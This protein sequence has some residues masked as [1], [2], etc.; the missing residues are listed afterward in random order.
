VGGIII[1]LGRVPVG[2]K[3]STW[4]IMY[5]LVLIGGVVVNQTYKNRM[6]TFTAV[7]GS[8]LLVT[9]A[10]FITGWPV[11]QPQ[12]LY[13]PVLQDWIYNFPNVAGARAI[14]IGIG[15]GIISTSIRYILGI[16]KSYIGE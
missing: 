3:I 11:D 6:I 16:E 1:M 14:M 5:I 2:S 8:L 12:I 7:G 4:F 15:L 13:L 9:I 10:G